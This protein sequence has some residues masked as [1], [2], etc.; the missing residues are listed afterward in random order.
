MSSPS[1]EDASTTVTRSALAH[2]PDNNAGP[3]MHIAALVCYLAI[4]TSGCGA[5]RQP[6]A[7]APAPHGRTTWV[8]D[9][10]RFV[11]HGRPLFLVD[12]TYW[13]WHDDEWRVWRDLGWRVARP[14]ASLTRMDR[15]RL[16][17]ESWM[18]DLTTAG[19]HP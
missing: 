9:G 10:V 11:D 16:H 4:V 2:S 8:A 18:F 13:Y 1:Y 7:P 3:P 6:L 17:E 5:P 12:G 15:G 19:P 14:P